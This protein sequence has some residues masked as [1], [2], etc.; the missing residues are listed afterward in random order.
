VGVIQTYFVLLEVGICG[1]VCSL[2]CAWEAVVLEACFFFFL[3]SVYCLICVSA[4]VSAC[5]V[6]SSGVWSGRLL[7]VGLPGCDY[8][9]AC[10]HLFLYFTFAI[11]ICDAVHVSGMSCTSSP[12]MRCLLWEAGPGRRTM[13]CTIVFW[14]LPAGILP[15]MGILPLP[16]L[17]PTGANLFCTLCTFSDLPGGC[18]S[19][20]PP[21]Y[22]RSLHCILIYVSQVLWLVFSTLPYYVHFWICTILF[23][24]AA[25]CWVPTLCLY[26]CLYAGVLGLLARRLPGGLCLP[27]VQ[28]PT[29]GVL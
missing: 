4:W 16:L 29:G 8:A 5:C 15:A 20:L 26:C 13:M 6:P 22:L 17:L 3:P 28:V 9:G 27:G 12:F 7:E 24:A 19:V 10:S 1:R 23:G 18:S 14:S 21:F 11:C 25:A 2:P